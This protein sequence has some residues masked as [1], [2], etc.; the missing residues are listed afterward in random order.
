MQL[1]SYFCHRS[2]IERVR[3]FKLHVDEK[4][5]SEGGGRFA[6]AGGRWVGTEV[7]LRMYASVYVCN[8]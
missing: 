1:L 2:E 3:S 4:Q 6:W 5:A 8:N 7:F